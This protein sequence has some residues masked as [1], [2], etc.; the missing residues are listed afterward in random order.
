MHNDEY[1]KIM[2]ELYGDLELMPDVLNQEPQTTCTADDFDVVVNAPAWVRYQ[3]QI[4]CDF[5][6]S[7]GELYER[8]FPKLGR[9]FFVATRQGRVMAYGE[10]PLES[11]LA[12][13]HQVKH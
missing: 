11:I 3:G 2:W 10:T 7:G 5:L 12:W 8:H 13:A 4:I 9:T 6:E 1:E